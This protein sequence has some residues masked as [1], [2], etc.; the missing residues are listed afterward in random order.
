MR[1]QPATNL[2]QLQQR[3]GD[4][5][6]GSFV[7]PTPDLDAIQPVVRRVL[8][9]HQV[10]GV[11]AG[12]TI[13]LKT[14]T[15]RFGERSGAPLF[16]LGTPGDPTFGL[17]VTPEGSVTAHPSA[18]GLVADGLKITA[19]TALLCGQ[20]VDA[21]TAHFLLDSPTTIVHR[22]NDDAPVVAAS[23]M[24]EPTS[25][26]GVDGPVV[27]WVRARRSEEASRLRSLCVLPHQL[28]GRP[29][30][31]E[32]AFFSG[33]LND[34]RF[35]HAV[36]GLGQLRYAL[37]LDPSSVNGA[38]RSALD[39]LTG[40]PS[41]PVEFD[42]STQA[43][44]IV[45]SPAFGSAIGGWIALSLTADSH[46]QLLG[47]SVHAKGNTSEWS[48]LDSLPHTV[49]QASHRM[50]VTVVDQ[51]DIPA[52]VGPGTIVLLEPGQAIPT[53]CGVV[54]NEETEGI[55][56]TDQTTGSTN[57]GIIPIGISSLF[58]MEIVFEMA[59][60]LRAMGVTS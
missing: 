15:Y 56:V 8:Q 22:R 19:P 12:G 24:P 38:T 25:G 57:H 30:Q 4:D 53:G 43:I 2:E 7:N 46:P 55:S 49:D 60:H 40:L 1:H 23:P 21:G 13:E 28:R 39:E 58:G 34:G 33:Q 10:G 41:V 27:A 20:V 48:W 59:E 36:I 14:G 5:F 37:P 51:A 16:E 18:R 45:G 3:L 35:G 42:L 29:K 6:E 31:G 26:R 54:L 17:T 47:V 9:L 44:A 50:R 11:M 32:G 52:Q